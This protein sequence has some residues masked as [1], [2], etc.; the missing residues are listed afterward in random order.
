MPLESK[1]AENVLI[2]KT[3]DMSQIAAGLNVRL[4]LCCS[5]DHNFIAQPTVNY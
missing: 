4:L 2:R 1:L 5:A 3:Q